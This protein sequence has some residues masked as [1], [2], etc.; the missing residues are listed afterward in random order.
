MLPAFVEH[1]HSQRTKFLA[2]SCLALVVLLWPAVTQ[3]ADPPIEVVITE[4]A[5]MPLPLRIL[6]F[7]TTVVVDG[8]PGRQALG[9]DESLVV[10]PGVYV[11]NRYN[12]AQDLRIS[13]R[14]FGTRAN[15]GIRGVKI[16]VDGIPH[17][18]PDGQAQVDS[19]DLAAIDRIEIKRGPASALYGNASGG[20]VD[21]R[22]AHEERPGVSGRAA[23]GDFGFHA[24]RLHAAVRHENWSGSAAAAATMLDGFRV[25]SASDSRI[26]SAQALWKSQQ[27]SWSIIANALDSPLAQDPGGL[28]AAEAAADPRQASRRNLLFDAGETVTQQ[29]LGISYERRITPDHHVRVRAYGFDRDFTNRLPFVEG[30][31]VQLD[32]ALAGAGLQWTGNLDVNGANNRYT[33]GLDLD[34][35]D[36]ERRRFNNEQ[37]VPGAEVFSQN[38]RVSSLGLFAQDVIAVYPSVSLTIGAR[39]DSV[40][41]RV[42]DHFIDDGDDSGQRA[43]DQLSPMFGISWQLGTTTSIYGNITTSFETPTTTE[44]ANPSGGGFNPVLKPQTATNYELGIKT[45]NSSMDLSVALYHISVV[46][47]IVP[48]ELPRS[49]GRS[50]FRN[51]GR[52]AHDGFE[53]AF[54]WRPSKS[55]R[56]TTA[57]TYSDYVFDEFATPA[58]VFDGNRLPGIPKHLFACEAAF[59]HPQGWYANG[60]LRYISDQFADDANLTKVNGY[61][62]LN[63]RA[64]TET[65]SGGWKFNIFAGMNN[66]TSEAY[67]D[68]LRINAA[69]GRY[70]EPAPGRNIYTGLEITRELR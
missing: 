49:P 58:G 60:D 11:Q 65:V 17:S 10:V 54:T 24:Y 9:L 70:F 52:S 66:V 41:F 3:G 34:H 56:L 39:F 63:L 1:K 33:V 5:R 50:F 43:F 16:F 8:L 26:A 2:A 18:L 23:F 55:W 32:R 31:S 19:L 14:G 44:L 51:T 46:D 7:A 22:S 61:T 36:D 53:A 47:E 57:Y 37:G 30:G 40:D 69:A 68:N 62:V 29:K 42:D 38:E 67:F 20:V 15:F 27:S 28:T 25:H 45:R 64:G 13:I 48:F 4:S 35:Q 21:L 6:P 59:S 12:L